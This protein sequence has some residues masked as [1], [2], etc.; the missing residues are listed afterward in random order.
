MRSEARHPNLIRLKYE[1]IENL[2]QLLH[3]HAGNK[4]EQH[5]LPP[6]NAK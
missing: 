6:S 3:H 4:N 2:R 1:F 5:R